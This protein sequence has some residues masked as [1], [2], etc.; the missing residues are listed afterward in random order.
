MTTFT[1]DTIKQARNI[2]ETA[3]NACDCTNEDYTFSELKELI[4]EIAGKLT[5][6]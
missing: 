2:L 5:Y 6:I 4:I 1:T 3:N